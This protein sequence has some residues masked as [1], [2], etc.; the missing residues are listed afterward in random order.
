MRIAIYGTRGAPA[1]WGGFDTLVTE[2]A[3]RPLQA[4]H[5]VT[6][7]CMPKFTGPEVGSRYE[8]FRVV[9]LPTVHG[10]FTET[11]LYGLLSSFWSPVR[12]KRDIYRVLGC[13]T[14]WAHLPHLLLRRTLVINTDGLDWQ[15]R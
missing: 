13:R 8:G 12:T 3:L 7:F 2:M 10:K 6:L 4:S 1:A 15:R 9:R 11:V 5:E 14:D